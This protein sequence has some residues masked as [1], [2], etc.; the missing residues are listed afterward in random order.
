VT[1][2]LDPTLRELLEAAGYAWRD[3]LDVW[4][5]PKTHRALDGDVAVTLTVEQL[6]FWLDEGSAETS[7]GGVLRASSEGEAASRHARP[8]SEGAGA[9]EKI[10]AGVRLPSSM[11]AL[12]TVVKTETAHVLVVEDHAEGREALCAVL[13]VSGYRVASVATGADALALLPVEVFDAV[14][15]DLGLPAGDGI[16]VIRAVRE[17][18]NPPAAIVFTGHNRLRD[19][20]EQNGCDAFVLKPELDELLRRLRS[21]IADRRVALRKT[22]AEPQ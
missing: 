1:P 9:T 19:V 13:D 17:R 15:L 18:P 10:D 3:Q 12:G 16:D 6:V 2:I 14:I 21:L 22:K 7:R 8:Q 4:E 11:A 20:A 5:H